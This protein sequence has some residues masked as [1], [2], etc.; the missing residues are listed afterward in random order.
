MPDKETMFLFG[1]KDGHL[2]ELR[3]MVD[4]TGKVTQ[5]ESG[6]M[7]SDGV[8]RALEKTGKWHTNKKSAI[9]I[10]NHKIFSKEKN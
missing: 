8:E 2:N 9:I 6:A 3:I 10:H 1:I 7:P 5:F 4:S